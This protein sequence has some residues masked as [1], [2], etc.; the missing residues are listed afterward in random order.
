[1]SE[2]SNRHGHVL[3]WG[4]RWLGNGRTHFRLYAPAQSAPALIVEDGKAE[5]LR[6][7]GDGMFSLETAAVPGQTYRFQLDDGTRIPDPVSREQ[8]D[9]VHGPSRIVDPYAFEWSAQGW[10]GRAW[11]ASVIYELHA[12][13]CGGFAGVA[14]QLP[15]LAQLGIT[16]I[17]LMPVADFPGA[18][19][20]GYDGVLPFAP[21]TAYGR[22]QDF[23]RMIDQAHQLGLS[24]MLDV[25]YNHFGPDGNYLHACAPMF[26]RDDV[27]TPWGA[28]IDFRRPEVRD[29]FIHNALYWVHEYRLDGLRFD[30]VHA[31]QDPTFLDELA[32]RVRASLPPDR[33]VHLVLENEHNDAQRL[34]R[35]RGVARRFD[36]QWNDDF[37]NTV[38]VL[39]TGEREGYY[40]HYAD[41]PIERL[42]RCLGEGFV[43]QGESVEGA[44]GRTRGSPSAHLPPTAFVNFLQNHDQVG[45]RAMGERLLSLCAPEALRAAA[46]M[47]LLSP[48]IPLLF[49]GEE[50][51]ATTP[52][53]FFTDHHDE[54]GRQVREGRRQE[55]ARF[56][57]FADPQRRAQ[58]PDPNA[59]STFE[60][61]NPPFGD[62]SQRHHREWL[63]YYRDLIGVRR[64]RL[65]PH[66]AG[67]R[68]AG[69]DV[70]GPEAVVARWR[71][72]DGTRWILAVNLGTR[73]SSFVPS[74]GELLAE[75]RAGA[76]EVR[77]GQLP[78]QYACAFC[79]PAGTGLADR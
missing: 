15:A 56:A 64:E 4:A 28:A 63:A 25:V 33:Q 55:F 71:F 3:P 29:Y 75:S 38:H 2:S 44:N 61:S 59:L 58:I 74:Q 51:G 66:L 13:V 73:T 68:S 7:E 27:R 8:A 48:P 16:T 46:L 78:P 50:W 6:A 1:M 34:E 37:H 40:R 35:D 21:D 39:L 12:G 14:A 65:V 70:I 26:F 17:E 36:A 18:R 42:A 47:H 11:E 24:V 77:H 57:A 43:Y 60:Q 31:I 72:D 45:N 79:E 22:P 9:D 30:A 69:A 62:A 49:I 76:A 23:K 53:L 10:R 54:L 5:P 20:W 52:F 19:N 32:Q 67:L 41:R